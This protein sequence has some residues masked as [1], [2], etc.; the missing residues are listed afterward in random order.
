MVITF[1][2][3]GIAEFLIKRWWR[4]FLYHYDFISDIT[5]C[6]HISPLIM[7]QCMNGVTFIWN[8]IKS[9]R[10]N[11]FHM[12]LWLSIKVRWYLLNVHSVS[13]HIFQNLKCSCMNK[14]LF[15]AWTP[16]SNLHQNLLLWQ[17]DNKKSLFHSLLEKI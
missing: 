4:V 8:L 11:P 15:V 14:I 13:E 6:I 2:M 5:W 7:I 1:F 17:Q 16:C 12:V 3:D 9:L 10:E